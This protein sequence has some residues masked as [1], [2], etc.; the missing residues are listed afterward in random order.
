MTALLATFYARHF[1]IGGL[2]STSATF[3]LLLQR[4]KMVTSRSVDWEALLKK[5]RFSIAL[6]HDGR[7]GPFQQEEHTLNH[8]FGVCTSQ[9]YQGSTA[10]ELSAFGFSGRPE[11]RYD[12]KTARRKRDQ[13]EAHEPVI[14]LT[15]SISIEAFRS[16]IERK[17]S[18]IAGPAVALNLD[19]ANIEEGSPVLVEDP[20]GWQ[21]KSNVIFSC[22]VPTWIVLLKDFKVS[23]EFTPQPFLLDTL[24]A[25]VFECSVHH[26]N[27]VRLSTKLP[28]SILTGLHLPEENGPLSQGVK[29]VR[30]G[31]ST[32]DESKKVQITHKIIFSKNENRIE[33]I[34]SGNPKDQ[35]VK[36]MSISTTLGSISL[37]R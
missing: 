1:V 22:M 11:D 20:E 36:P 26:Y 4:L 33:R 10:G 25:K 16:L 18:E 24:P 15:L 31:A 3:S 19:D 34:V 6:I 35:E 17:K 13:I 21:G 8:I 12:F 9:L 30:I 14:C 32:P 7:I 29:L 27:N 23:L 28:L 5:L 37:T 2:Y